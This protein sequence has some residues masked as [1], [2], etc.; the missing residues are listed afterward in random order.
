MVRSL[1]VAKLTPLVVRPPTNTNTGHRFP[2]FFGALPS[3]RMCTTTVRQGCMPMSNSCEKVST[4]SPS[5]NPSF[6]T[7]TTHDTT[8]YPSHK[9]VRGEM[10]PRFFRSCCVAPLYCLFTFPLHNT[11]DNTTCYVNGRIPPFLTT[12]SGN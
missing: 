6:P 1:T 12:S 4:S 9:P 7:D 3:R 8:L 2:G 10:R 11:P 5:P